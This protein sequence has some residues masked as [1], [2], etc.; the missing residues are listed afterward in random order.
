L[1]LYAFGRLIQPVMRLAIPSV[2]TKAGRNTAHAHGD[3]KKAEH[4]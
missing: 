3:D 4:G 2:G 1:E